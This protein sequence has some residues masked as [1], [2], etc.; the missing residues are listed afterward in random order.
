[1]IALL[2][3]GCL[4]T[5]GVDDGPEASFE[6]LWRDFDELYALFGV[7]DIDWAEGYDTWRPAVGPDSDDAALHEA[8]TGLLGPLD[9]NHVHLLVPDSDVEDWTAGILQDLERED[10][11]PEV[12]KG[13]LEDPVEWGEDLFYGRIGGAGYVYVGTFSHADYL[14]ALDEAVES[15]G[16]VAGV[17]LDVRDNGG[18]YES[19]AEAVAGRFVPSGT[20]YARARK[21][22]G[23]G[24]EDFGEWLEYRVEPA[25]PAQYTGPVVVLTHRFTVSAAEW[26]V[27][28]MR[29]Y[30]HVTTAG[31]W[32]SGAFG[33]SVWRD[34]PNGWLY[35]VT[36]TDTRDSEGV[37]WEGEGLA[38]EIEAG[39]SLEELQAGQ[40]RALEAA[41]EVLG[42]R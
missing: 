35:S 9:D 28:A 4:L 7:K 33:T 21:R 3:A 40:D 1:M 39:S 24:H 17:I 14:D 13:Y 32:T 8:L 6:H 42:A 36:T 27:L 11:H 19:H 16:D 23:P 30:D 2:L 41:L 29:G 26:F 5:A 12:V 18:G 20:D 25:G 15:F 34:L 37:S 22:E 10:F 38:P 31:D